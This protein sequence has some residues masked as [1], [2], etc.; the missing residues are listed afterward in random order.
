MPPTPCP[1]CG[2]ALTPG[3]R[4]C[5]RCGR[6]VTT[7]PPA[8]RTA[9]IVS[10]TITGLALVAI[11]WLLARSEQPWAGSAALATPGGFA[12]PAPDISTMT[13]RQAFDRLFNRA[14]V[15][16]ERGDSANVVRFTEHAL[17]AYTQLDSVDA[18]GRYHAGMLNAQVG[19]FEPAL[20]LADTILQQ[21]PSHL[22]AY[23]IRGA[24]AEAR[25]DTDA[26]ARA[27]KD[28]LA[29]WARDPGTGRPEYADHQQ[30]LDQFHTAAAPSR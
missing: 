25:R 4:F 9:W 7:G 8:N 14:M 22:F 6:E 24:V 13:A 19:Q 17:A 26:L 29:A 23:L 1:A 11:V 16:A 20:A 21:H 15:A 30:E 2:A 10:L 12:G 28:F 5:H 18:D 3:E 27:R